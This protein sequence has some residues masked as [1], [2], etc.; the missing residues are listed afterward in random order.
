MGLAGDPQIRST[1]WA[2]SL[3]LGGDIHDS[4]IFKITKVSSDISILLNDNK[5]YFFFEFIK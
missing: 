4:L 3:P 1:G 2:L 5:N